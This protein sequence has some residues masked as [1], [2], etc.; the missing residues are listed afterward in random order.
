MVVCQHDLVGVPPRVK[1]GLRVLAIVPARG[2]SDRVPYLNIKRLGDRP[3]LA[4]TLLA[5]Q[6]ATVVDRLIVSTDDERVA[7]VARAHGAEVP[8][9]RPAA[10]SADIP[11]LK[12]VVVHAVETLEAGGEHADVVVVL[13]ATTPFRA[14]AASAWCT[15][16]STA[17]SR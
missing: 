3:L 5:G 14:A 13:Q 7:E 8:F 12:P 9:L 4:H 17:S 15:A 16:A 1:D 6:S 11:S 10:L 2:G